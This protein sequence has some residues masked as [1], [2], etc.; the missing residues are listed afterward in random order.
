MSSFFQS[1]SAAFASFN[2]SPR[3]SRSDND[4]QRPLDERRRNS[5]SQRRAHSPSPRRRPPPS[6][7]AGSR[8]RIKRAKNEFSLGLEDDDDDD[9]DHRPDLSFQS[10]RD[11]AAPQASA[12]F[13]PTDRISHARQS[14]PIR[15]SGK[16]KN[17]D[18]FINRTYRQLEDTHDFQESDRPN[19]RRRHHEGPR[20]VDLTHENA[21]GSVA[22]E[23][24]PSEHRSSRLS[25]VSN[26]SATNP[27][28]KGRAP[29]VSEFRGVEAILERTH[30][31]HPG[32]RRPSAASSADEFFTREAAAQRRSSGS[33]LDYT[34]KPRTQVTL[35]F[36]KPRAP[37]GNIEVP[38]PEQNHSGDVQPQTVTQPL[39]P[40]KRPPAASESGD[41]PDELQGDVTT[42]PPPKHLAEKSP[43][44]RP[45][46]P[47]EDTVLSPSRK[48]SPSDIEPASFLPSRKKKKVKR[49]QQDPEHRALFIQSIRFGPI[50]KLVEEGED[51]V[52]YM[53]PDRIVLGK[54]ITSVGPEEVLFRHV[55][56]IYQAANS[57]KVRLLL[58]GYEGAPGSKFDIHFSLRSSKEAFVNQMREEGGRV[59]DKESCVFDSIQ[60]G[61]GHWTNSSN[62]KWL[63]D[64]FSIY[65]HDMRQRLTPA[66]SPLQPITEADPLPPISSAVQHT[67]GKK[68]SSMLEG[69]ASE[70]EE[71]DQDRK[72]RETQ[73]GSKSMNTAG[74]AQGTTKEKP[75]SKEVGVEIP[76][77]KFVSKGPGETETRRS[78]RNTTRWKERL[79]DNDTSTN[80]SD[81]ALQNDPF[82]KKWKKPLVYPK[83]GKKKE[84]VNVDDRDRLRENEFLNDNLIAFYTRFLQDHLERTNPDAAKR[85]YFFNSYF[86]A[87]LT[88]KGSREINY[89]GV[90]KW[91]SKVN[92]FSYDYIV[93]PIN[94]NA[95]W[96]VAIICNLPSLA[97]G[98]VKN[99]D[100]SS[101]LASD[102]ES[103]RGPAKEVQ[104]ILESPEPETAPASARLSEEESARKQNPASTSPPSEEARQSFA[105][106]TLL[107]EKNA[108]AEAEDQ[109]KPSP[110]KDIGPDHE[111]SPPSLAETLAPSQAKSTPKQLS[112]GKSGKK[113]GGVKLDPEQT[114]II[115]FDSLDANRSPT[116]R[117][118]R[119]YICKEAKNKLNV[120]IKNA[121]S[122]IKGMRAQNIPLQPNYS[123]CGLYLLA[124]LENFVRSP[125]E[126]VVKVLQRE[127]NV[128]QDWPPLGS[129]LLRLRMRDFLD[130]LY[131]EQGSDMKE[132]LMVDRQ[133]ISF[134][135]GP[136]RPP[137]GEV[138]EETKKIEGSEPTSLKVKEDAE[139]GPVHDRSPQEEENTSDN[140]GTDMP[141]L[142][143][144]A[145]LPLQKSTKPAIRPST[146]EP[147]RSRLPLSELEEIPDSQ[148]IAAPPS[149]EPKPDRRKERKS[150]QARDEVPGD[151]REHKRPAT[152]DNTGAP[153][154]LDTEDQFPRVEIQVPCTP[155]RKELK[156]VRQSPRGLNRR[157]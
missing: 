32:D 34:N 118:L 149:P 92:L 17:A 107:E 139:E 98:P 129:G 115:T 60:S 89:D 41:S 93:V 66:R 28:K 55:R 140:E 97:L 42:R 123:D 71:Q 50:H 14:G 125:D 33:S 90:E 117:L 10:P 4:P 12:A 111:K 121:S 154:D 126:F 73:D 72:K 106:M 77:K 112:K 3:L 36:P 137:Q 27:K 136:P 120:E 58:N 124:Y 69:S 11:I 134:L 59:Q 8:R 143:P 95:H 48:R 80:K 74:P 5:F 145:A 108:S 75:K 70:S 38:D 103:P 40:S 132:D 104:E 99:S 26:V 119:E 102:K 128:E 148:E 113:R 156:Q 83:I 94:Q 86:F 1:L 24:S 29:F 52:I 82:R 141:I 61:W 109:K 23:I 63:D 19:K 21:A 68:L 22:S 47:Q 54:D 84:E 110:R 96:Y 153:G 18:G 135:L 78:T 101:A 131:M 15:A 127:M 65:D 116:V 152:P 114:A 39:T 57:K 155:P 151:R 56:V 85:V 147:P 37:L 13:Q 25:P 44:K 62:R 64:A 46:N 122:V 142:V 144:T 53:C 16:S 20:P 87:T 88:N 30:N 35:E 2:S 76:V 49:G 130:Q 133:P 31:P 157:V 138:D 43:Q 67:K 7:T 81:S 146:P 91:T 9:D 100:A 51:A 79:D 6:P 45:Q 150:K 105:S